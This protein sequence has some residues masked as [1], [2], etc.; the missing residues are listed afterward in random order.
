[1]RLAASL[2]MLRA[3]NMVLRKNRMWSMRVWMHSL[4]MIVR[5]NSCFYTRIVYT[6]LAEIK[7]EY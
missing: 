2:D 3:C 6:K 4:V 7:S 5:V 1:M